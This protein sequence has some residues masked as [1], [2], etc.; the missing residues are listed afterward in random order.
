MHLIAQVLVCIFLDCGLQTTPGSRMSNKQ[1]EKRDEV[2]RRMLKTP[3][4]PHKPVGK[5]RRVSKP[6]AA[7]KLVKAAD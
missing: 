2:L 6:K 3:P 5:R 7:K 1:D 4:K